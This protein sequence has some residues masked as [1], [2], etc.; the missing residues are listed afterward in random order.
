MIYL[1]S[2]SSNT[3]ASTFPLR[4]VLGLGVVLMVAI[5]IAH[6]VVYSLNHHNAFYQD[7]VIISIVVLSLAGAFINTFVPP[8]NLKSEPEVSNTKSVSKVEASEG[9]ERRQEAKVI[10]DRKQTTEETTKVYLNMTLTE[11]EVLKAWGTEIPVIT[12]SGEVVKV[13]LDDILLF[14]DED[15]YLEVNSSGEYVTLHYNDNNPQPTAEQGE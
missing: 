6:S 13:L 2:V 9:E 11:E 7:A 5:F 14:K 15:S 8:T 3:L 12:E 1:S 4:E 10:E